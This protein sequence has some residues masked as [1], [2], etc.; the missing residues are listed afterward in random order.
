M[1]PRTKLLASVLI[2]L[3]AAGGCSR[4]PTVPESE[5]GDTVRSVMNSQ[6][7]DYE[8]A[9]HPNPDA[10]EGSDAGRLNNVVTAYRQHITKPEQVRQPIA[11]NVSGGN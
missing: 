8:A 11:I 2:T 1:K 10:V 6:I 9:I 4:Q 3:A 5:F 7:N